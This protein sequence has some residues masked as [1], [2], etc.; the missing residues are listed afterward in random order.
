MW[1]MSIQFWDLV[2]RWAIFLAFPLGVLAAAAALISG[3]V[4][5]KLTDIVQK[6]ADRR[7]EELRVES[8]AANE[9]AAE[10]E[11]QAAELK[12]ANLVLEAKIRPRRISGEI[13][14]QM[15]S[16][17]SMFSGVPIAVV[18]RVF[19]TEGKDFADD[20]EIVFRNAGW[21]T[22]R[23]DTLTLPDKGVFIATMEDTR[24]PPPIE[25]AIV[26]ALAANG[27]ECKPIRI[28]EKTKGRISP[29]FEPNVLYLLVG[30][31]P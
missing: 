6:D 24:L 5:Y 30:A 23:N 12:A 26:D 31:R 18:S 19:D 29:N 28:N 22:V 9:R 21:G 14:S 8:A 25:K 4:G 7:I 13:S 15:S 2:V 17:L 16:I 11:K 27:T 10:L 1:G 20:L 3:Y